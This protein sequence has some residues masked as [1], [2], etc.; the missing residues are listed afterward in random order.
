MVGTFVYM[1]AASLAFPYEGIYLRRS[2]GLSMSWIGVL[3]GVVPL[4]MI[5]LQVWG[6][7]LTDRIGRRR[8][9]ILSAWMGVVWFVGFAFVREIW[10]VAVLVAME[11]AFGWP[12]FLTASGAMIADLLPPARR[13]EAF[14]LSRAA[15]NLGVVVGPAAG[16][17]VLATGASFRTL[18][19]LAAAGCFGFTLLTIWGVKETRAAAQADAVES[20]EAHARTGYRVVLAD[21]WFLAFCLVALLPVACFGTFGAIYSV[22]LVNDVGIPY[23]TWGLLLAFNSG[24]IVVLQYPLIRMTRGADR[25]LLLALASAL[26]GLG[27]GL[28]ALVHTVWP[29]IALM[30]VLSFGEMLLSPLSAS[31]VSDMAP[32]A[33]RGRYMGVWTVV[34]SGGMGLG[35]SLAGFSMDALGGRTTYLLVLVVGMLGGLLF[36]G[37]RSA[38]RRR[39]PVAPRGAQ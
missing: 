39:L 37:L 12:L 25:L 1:S 35:P 30:A 11:S 21:R 2:L 31:L 29:L 8:M 27:L 19:L 9:L 13:A 3:F 20:P 16:G 15:M 26:L 23:G 18:F 7:A 24:I 22:F 10:Q 34:W 6:G 28:S 14:S 5:P 33:V 4:T 17:L 32:A 36:L 38:Q